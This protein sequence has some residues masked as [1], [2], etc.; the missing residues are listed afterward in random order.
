[1]L[2]KALDQST[3]LL[4]VR[5]PSRASS[6]PTGFCVVAGFGVDQRSSTNGS[7]L[8]AGIAQQISTCPA[9]GTSAG[10]YG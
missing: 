6:A 4:N 7:E 3:S 1:M 5:P 2:A 8:F 10:G 9:S